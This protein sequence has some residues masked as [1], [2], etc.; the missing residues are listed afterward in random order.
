M[1]SVSAAV[2]SVAL[3]FVAWSSHNTGGS[4][5]GMPASAI[6]EAVEV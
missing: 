3:F 4:L 5:A 6:A 2:A 1:R